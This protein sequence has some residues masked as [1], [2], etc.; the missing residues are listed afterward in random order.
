MPGERSDVSASSGLFGLC[1]FLS[2]A[3]QGPGRPWDKRVTE[4]LVTPPLGDTLDLGQLTE[5]PL[6]QLWDWAVSRH[7]ESDLWV[8]EGRG[9]VACHPPS[10]VPLTFPSSNSFIHH[11]F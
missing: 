5:G 3:R 2:D 1:S 11:Y 7:I 9:P 10:S 6:D 4:E 8:R